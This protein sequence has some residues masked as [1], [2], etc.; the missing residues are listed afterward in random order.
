MATIQF[1]RRT[2]TGKGPLTGNTGTVK[3]G[4]PLVDFNSGNLYIAKADKTASTSNP[5]A[6]TDYLQIPGYKTVIDAIA[7][8]ID[9]EGFGTAAYRNI[10]TANGQVPVLNSD[11]KLADSVIPKIAMTNTFVVSSQTAMLALSTAQEG[12]VAVRTDQNKSYILKA[13]GASTLAN[14]QELLTPTDKVQSVN[15]KTG[16]VNISLSDLGGASSSA[17]NSHISNGTHL[18]ENQIETIANSQL[19]KIW[20]NV[21]CILED[22]ASDFD[23]NVLTGGL[24]MRLIVNSGYN[25]SI[26][27][28]ELG[29]DKNKILT[30]SSM[31]DGG[32]F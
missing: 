9:N 1:K 6:Y 4:E 31:I 24:L 29:I 23:S 26:N 14:W 30:P 5:L 2:S 8:G 13:A 12:D 32:T 22:S 25:P 11:G 10:G 27:R 19:T 20:E 16:T 21:G 17:L 18:T 7:Y 3:A 15:G 28:Y